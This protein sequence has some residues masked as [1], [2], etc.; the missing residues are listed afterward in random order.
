MNPQPAPFPHADV[1]EAIGEHPEG[2]AALDALQTELQRNPT[3]PGA[4]REHVD[5]LR[6]VPAAGQIVEKWF[7]SPATQ[8][9]FEV[10]SNIGL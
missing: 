6:R 5:T 4:V 10:L 7:E 9:W 3:D 1:R 8:H 2:S